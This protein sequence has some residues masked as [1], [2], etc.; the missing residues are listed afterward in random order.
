MEKLHKSNQALTKALQQPLTAFKNPGR[1]PQSSPLPPAQVSLIFTS[2][3]TITVDLDNT[4]V[5][6]RH[7]QT[8][9]GQTWVDL[10]GNGKQD[11]GVSRTHA[12]LEVID[13]N[14]FVKDTHSLNGTF[15]NDAELYPLRN[16][17]IQDGDT[18]TL[19]KVKLQVKL[20]LPEKR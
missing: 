3:K 19:G 6:G 12:S 16:Y 7:A 15:L 17:V 11:N 4:I 14:V 20:V 18:L 1:R 9:N 10:S 2:G 8:T 5:L 13:G